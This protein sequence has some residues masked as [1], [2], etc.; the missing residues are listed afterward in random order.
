MIETNYSAAF[1]INDYI[2]HINALS[3]DSL[4]EAGLYGIWRSPEM[5]ILIV[6][7]RLCNFDKPDK[8]RVSFIGIDAQSAKM[9]IHYISVYLKNVFPDFE[10]Q[11]PIGGLKLVREMGETWNYN[12]NRLSKIQRHSL[13]QTVDMLGKLVA[14]AER[15]SPVDLHI[16]VVEQSLAF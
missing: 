16:K 3:L 8:E 15:P 10:E 5:A 12:I 11:L 2:H 1:I 7:M 6:W 4:M 13:V 14:Q 9:A